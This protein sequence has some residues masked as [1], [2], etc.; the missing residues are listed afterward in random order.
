VSLTLYILKLVGLR[1]LAAGAIV[2]SVL[3]ILDL[4]DVTPQIVERGLG[5]AG[6]LQYALLRLPRLIDQAAPLSILA[7]GIFAFIK[8]A[9]ESEFV[10]MRATGVSVYRLVAMALPAAALVVVVHVIAVEVVAPRT[11]PALEAWWRATAPEGPAE[12][13]A[14]KSL[15]VGGDVFVVASQDPS[16][17]TLSE[18]RIYRRDADGR[19]IERIESSGAVYESQGWRLSDAR[20]VRFAD[21]AT[22]SGEAGE[23]ILA[24][25]FAP[26]DVRALFFGDQTT[27]SAAA[28][29]RALAG[30]GSQRPPSYYA[31]RLQ[32]AL[33][34]PFGDLLMLLLAA[35]IALASFRGGQGAVFATLSLGAGL[36]YLVMDGLLVALGESGAIS[37]ALAAWTAPLV[38]ASLAG[39][40][41]LKLEG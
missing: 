26:A 28:A 19:L 1:I 11:D 24:P 40:I 33:A 13:T 20:F 23:V 6:M 5:A 34:G 29:G 41:L 14:T 10:A 9:S 36:L 12:E 21:G 4:L 3:Q 8:L 16:G 15:R 39:A 7:G 2:L 18:M 27:S 32:S 25:A 31:T 37:A 35:P 30:G 17:R 38:F 22:Q